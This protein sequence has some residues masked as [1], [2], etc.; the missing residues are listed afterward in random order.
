MAIR[1]T[2]FNPLGDR[3]AYDLD[4]C[5]PRD[6]WLQVDTAQDAWYYGTW[7]NPDRLEIVQYAEGDT[8]RIV[9]E[10]ADDY[11]RELREL[12]AWNVEAGHWKGIDPGLGKLRDHACRRLAELG[13][14]D[15]L[16]PEPEAAPA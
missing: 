13:L 6:G 4:H 1:H 14:S 11:V 16:H 2:S 10:D 5:P 8:T 9:C 15:L 7:T 12:H 3:Y